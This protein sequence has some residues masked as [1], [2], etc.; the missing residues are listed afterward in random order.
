MKVCVFVCVCR[1]YD[2][3]HPDWSQGLWGVLAQ[4]AITH[5]GAGWALPYTYQRLDENECRCDD[6]DTSSR[7]RVSRFGLLGGRGRGANILLRR[8]PVHWGPALGWG[9]AIVITAVL[10]LQPR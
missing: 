5:R 7:E 9:S 2:C 10:W 1:R 6:A 4:A 3:T 8:P